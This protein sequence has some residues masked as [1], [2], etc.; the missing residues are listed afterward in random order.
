MCDGE[1]AAKRIKCPIASSSYN[2]DPVK[3]A[4]KRE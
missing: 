1:S 4:Q 2:L 3:D